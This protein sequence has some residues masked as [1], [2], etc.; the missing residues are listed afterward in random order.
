MPTS[1]HLIKQQLAVLMSTA[2][3]VIQGYNECHQVAGQVAAAV[4]YHLL[5]SCTA[6]KDVQPAE[7]LAKLD[8]ALLKPAALQ[9]GASIKVG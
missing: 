5:Y 2:G 7:W 9:P 8:M 3:P 1:D 4:A 6:N